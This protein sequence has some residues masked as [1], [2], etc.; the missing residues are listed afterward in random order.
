M[1]KKNLLKNSALYLLTATNIIYAVLHGFSWLTATALILTTAVF[2]LDVK[3][4]LT[5]GKRKK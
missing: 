4:L 5:S 2:V 3:E 1:N